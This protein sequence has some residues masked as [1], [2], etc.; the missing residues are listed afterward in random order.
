MGAKIGAI[1]LLFLALALVSAEL[2]DPNALNSQL[3]QGSAFIESESSQADFIMAEW[4]KFLSK[5]DAIFM[6][7]LGLG[8]SWS[9]SFLFSFFI[10]LL[11][12]VYAYS[13]FS[14]LQLSLPFQRYASL[15]KLGAFAAFFVLISTIRIPRYSAHLLTTLV[16][17]LDALWFRI[18]AIFVVFALFLF[19]LFYVGFVNRWVR[20]VLYGKEI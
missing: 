13:L 6:T 3:E 10:W 8:F 16:E 5:Q 17:Q 1:I 2:P 12:I 7:L 14:V 20:K 11:L 18:I 9:L 4:G 19:A 15:A